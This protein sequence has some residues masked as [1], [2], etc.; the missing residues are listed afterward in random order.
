MA[1]CCIIHSSFL[2]GNQKQATK[3]SGRGTNTSINYKFTLLLPMLKHRGGGQEKAVITYI[4]G[5]TSQDVYQI[6]IIAMILEFLS[7]GIRTSLQK[8]LIGECYPHSTLSHTLPP[9]HS[10]QVI[11]PNYLCQTLTAYAGCS[12][13]CIKS[14]L[15]STSITNYC[16]GSAS[17]S[18]PT[19]SFSHPKLVPR[20]LL[21]LIWSLP[22]K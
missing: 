19:I 16:L 7:W 17:P 6:W 14:S 21:A 3:Q 11:I 13:T 2:I 12:P 20:L 9:N 10:W 18:S 15:V 5:T 1:S 8:L 22:K 4:Y